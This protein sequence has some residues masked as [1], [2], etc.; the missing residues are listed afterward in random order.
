MGCLLCI[1][2]HAQHAVSA[3]VTIQ[4]SVSYSISPNFCLVLE[5]VNTSCGQ[6][7]ILDPEAQG[8]MHQRLE[9]PGRQGSASLPNLWSYCHR[10][11]LQTMKVS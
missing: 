3:R 10:L 1:S 11:G 2:Y 9:A 5:A 4:V 6:S 8:S 7:A